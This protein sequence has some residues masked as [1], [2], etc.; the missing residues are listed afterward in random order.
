MK[1]ILMTMFL[2]SG[3]LGE[4][5]CQAYNM[6]LENWAIRSVKIICVSTGTTFEVSAWYGISFNCNKANVIDFS[7]GSVFKTV[8]LGC[9]DISGNV[10]SVWGVNKGVDCKMGSS[11]SLISK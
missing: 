11:H 3:L 7:S 8:T 1:K 6:G 9:W 2:A 5:L 10:S 4:N